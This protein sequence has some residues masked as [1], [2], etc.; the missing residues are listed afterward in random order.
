MT[1]AAPQP[2]W[3][4]VNILILIDDSSEGPMKTAGGDLGTSGMI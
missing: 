3:R 2:S 4:G 1:V